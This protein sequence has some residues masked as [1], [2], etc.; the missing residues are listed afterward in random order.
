MDVRAGSARTGG[1]GD[2]CSGQRA[3][4]LVMLG[5]STERACAMP[6]QRNRHTRITHVSP[7]EFPKRLKRFLEESGLSWSEVARRL[8]T[9]RPTVWRWAEGR[10]RPNHQ[11]RKALVE[12]ADRLSLGHLSFIS[13]Q[14]PVGLRSHP[15]GDEVPGK[16]RIVQERV[17]L[18]STSTPRG[19]AS[20]RGVFGDGH[21]GGRLAVS[22]RHEP[23]NR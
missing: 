16:P 21:R 12:V 19:G 5:L 20:V 6:R 15:G 14:R 9:Y 13:P 1:C 23:R 10:V 17:D 2:P 4:I 8:E 11:D 7:E 3:H 22:R 18:P